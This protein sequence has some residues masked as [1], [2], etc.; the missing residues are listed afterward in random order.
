MESEPKKE[1]TS[2]SN[3]TSLS[4][5]PLSSVSSTLTNP[6][7]T[8]NDVS[9]NITALQ[10]N[11][12]THESTP[13]PTEATSSPK[14]TVAVEKKKMADPPS[15]TANILSETD[16]KLFTKC[17]TW[18]SV[19]DQ[20]KSGICDVNEA[21]TILRAMGVYPSES[22]LIE[23]C[24]LMQDPVQPGRMRLEQFMKIAFPLIQSKAF[25]KDTDDQMHQSFMILD[26]E[27]K[28]YINVEDLK[29]Y[30]T[31]QGEKLSA[32]EFEIMIA[33]VDKKEN[34]FYYDDYLALL[35]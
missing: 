16:K 29:I 33:N 10:K 31:T 2:Q 13:L 20:N 30:L 12:P 24:M 26:K 21:G 34:K 28:G 22:K 15:A 11:L 5:N 27:K 3:L 18:F 19:F 8:I 32:E 6:S 14:E 1:T 17:H 4:P 35:L 23:L 25:P 7:N 9:T